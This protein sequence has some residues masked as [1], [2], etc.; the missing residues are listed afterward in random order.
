VS[1]T[2]N[3]RELPLEIAPTSRRGPKPSAAIE[4]LRGQAT[5]PIR[6]PPIEL[7]TD[8]VLAVRAL[9]EFPEGKPAYVARCEFVPLVSLT[10]N[11]E[12]P[13]EGYQEGVVPRSVAW[14]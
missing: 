11:A 8:R 12:T 14:S 1:R 9:T 2:S 5:A 4:G 10:E 6:L 7:L 3:G 13:S